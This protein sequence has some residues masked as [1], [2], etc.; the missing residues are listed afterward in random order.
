MKAARGPR[1]ESVP[2][3]AIILSGVAA[4]VIRVI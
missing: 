1:N 4:A 3:I 2:G